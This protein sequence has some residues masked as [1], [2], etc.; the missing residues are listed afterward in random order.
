MAGLAQ[1]QKRFGSG[2][3]KVVSAEDA[4]Y[5]IEDNSTLTVGGFVAQS[6]PEELL[7]A[8]GERFQREQSPTGLTLVFGGGPGDWDC[9][10]LNHLAKEGLIRRTVGAHYGQ[11]P[12]LGKM[13][14]AGIIE[15]YNLPLG[16]ISRMIRSAAAG[17]PGHITKVGFGTM[18]DPK[19]GGGR[20]NNNSKQDMVIEIEIEGQKY[21]MY[22]A[23]PIDVAFV[24]GTTGDEDGNITM[25]KESLYCDHL[26]Q[27]MAARS[28]RG[29][30]I[31]QV[32]RIGAKGTLH[33]RKVK[34]PGTVVDAVVVA[35]PENHFMSFPTQYEPAATAEIRQPMKF[36]LSQDLDERKIIARRASLQLVPG[37]VI[38]LGIGMPEGIAEVC[39]EEGV[40][41]DV[42]LTTE[43]GIH[44][45]V[46][47][48]GHN[49]GP[50]V[51]Y[52]A[53]IEMNQQFD[54]YNG[55][56]L[57][58]CFLGMA[59]LDSNGDVNVTR[60]GNKLTGPGGFIDISQSTKRVSLLGTFTAGGLE[61][62]VKDGKL[63]IVQEG[64]VKKFVKKVKEVTF[65]GSRAVEND[66]HVHYITERAVFS[67]TKDGVMLLEVAPGIDI[68][69]QVLDLMEFKP[70]IPEHVGT[71][72]PSIFNS[73]LMELKKSNFI[74]EWPD[75]L[76]YDAE[77]NSLFINLNFLK[78]NTPAD[79]KLT[80]DSISAFVSNLKNGKVNAVVNYDNCEIRPELL[81]EWEA[82]VKRLKD[83][84]YLTAR[85][86]TTRTFAQHRL[87]QDIQIDDGREYTLEGVQKFL[88]SHGFMISPEQTKFQFA[89]YLQERKAAEN[90]SKLETIDSARLK[91]IVSRC[92][93][94]KATAN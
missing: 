40:L 82:M 75:R 58:A 94:G 35:K 53:L 20:I 32:E 8:L 21:L 66:Q 45:G 22:R 92:Q 4:A 23:I 93:G 27:A 56:G 17:Q 83:A 28:T 48:S 91:K 31:A 6:C 47:M 25:E 13:A 39:N 54:F 5:L 55:G 29:T 43:P 64:K 74:L 16:S 65:S 61:I 12:M 85:R 49:F 71:M 24:R 3:N 72:N 67:L 10:G 86:F 38:N 79:V 77:T 11:V 36:A 57:D 62:A 73:G 89:K 50:A 46:G 78:V 90:N 88:K 2:R 41:S 9:K 19:H 76:T 87:R 51:N 15:A 80:E 42:E 68:Q 63:N 59:E 52:D 26:I 69:K 84:Y 60:V 7:K 37:Q 34:I 1:F 33:P 81:P 70:I 18:A 44:G 30:V 14:Q